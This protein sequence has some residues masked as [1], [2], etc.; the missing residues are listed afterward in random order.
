ME[1]NINYRK[2]S[3]LALV[4]FVLS[5][6]M[7]LMVG[8]TSAEN[9]ANVPDIPDVVDG[10]TQIPEVNDR[11][12]RD[13]GADL[14]IEEIENVEIEMPAIPGPSD[15]ADM[16]DEEITYVAE[17]I[18]TPEKYV[19]DRSSAPIEPVTMS[20]PP[21]EVKGTEKA[22]VIG[23]ETWDLAGSPYNITADVTITGTVTIDPGVVVQFNGSFYIYVDGYLDAVG[24]VA[25]QITFTSNMAV[26]APG[27]WG[28]I[29]IN[30]TGNAHI[31]YC[32]IFYATNAI[33]LRNVGSSVIIDYCA[34]IDCSGYGIVYSGTGDFGGMNVHDN[35]FGNSNYAIY[36]DIT[37]SSVV[38][39]T[40]GDITIVDN[41][42]GGTNGFR[43]SVYFDVV[44]GDSVT[45]GQTT[46]TGNSI[47]PTGNWGIYMD[48]W[49]IND[50]GAGTVNWGDMTITGN[51]IDVGGEDGIF[52]WGEFDTLASTT[53]N[54]GQIDVSNNGIDAPSQGIRWAWWQIETLTGTASVTAGETN[55]NDNTIDVGDEGILFIMEHIGYDMYDTA[56]VDI[57][58]ITIDP[59]VI[60]VPTNEEGIYFWDND[61]GYCGSEMYDDSTF[62]LGGIHV[63]D[64]DLTGGN[65]IT[66]NTD[67]LG[68]NN[69]GNSYASF[70]GFYVN[71]NTIDTDGANM[72]CISMPDF[73]NF[74]YDLH[75]Y[76][77]VD[78]GMFQFNSNV[79]VSDDDNGLDIT[80]F[81]NHGRYLYD[82]AQANFAGY[83]F[84][85]NDIDAGDDGIYIY[86]FE[87]HG[88]DLYGYSQVTQGDMSWSDNTI[89]AGVRGI[90]GNQWTDDHG[91]EMHDNSRYTRGDF[92]CQG[93]IIDANG[94][95]GIDINYITDQGQYLY[96]NAI[97]TFGGHYFTSNTIDATGAGMDID[98]VEEWG[99]E[100]Y[101][102]SQ[103]IFGVTQF[104]YNI[105]DCNGNGWDMDEWEYHGYVV[106]NAASATFGNFEFNGNTIS[107]NGD[108]GMHLDDLDH[109]GY[110]VNGDS[111]VTFGDFQCNGN[112]ITVN[113]INGIHAVTFG[114]HGQNLHD[115][116]QVTFGN[117][118]FNDNI[119]D[120]DE[121][122]ISLDD[123]EY[124]GNDLN[125]D[126]TATFG[127]FQVNGNEITTNGGANGRGLELLDFN[128]FGSD[129]H[130][131]SHASF[132]NF[133]FN[134][135]II[136]AD[137]YGIY[138]DDAED[139]GQ[140]LDGTCTATFGHFQMNNND[141]WA[142]DEDGFQLSDFEDHGRDLYDNSQVTFGNF[143]MNNN[144]IDA[145]NEGIEFDDI[146]YWG[147][148]VNGN[149][150]VT[151]GDIQFMTNT[152]WADNDDGF[153]FNDWY[154]L[155]HYV[156]DT[157]TVTFGDICFDHNYIDS[158]DYGFYLSDLYNWAYD[159]Y[160][161]GIVTFG[162]YSMS[163]NE[164]YTSDDEGIYIDDFEYHGEGLY[165][166]A[167]VVFGDHL[168]N[169]NYM[170][171]EG[172]GIYFED[173]ED[174]GYTMED[175]A[176][177][178]MG[179][180]LLNHNEIYSN[181]E[182]I[183][184]DPYYFGY[185]MYDNTVATY[186][187]FDLNGNYIECVDT[188]I[189]FE[190]EYF[191]YEL[192]N[193]VQVF[194]GANH[195]MN[196][197]V[198]SDDD[199]GIYA[200]WWY[201][202]GCYMYDNSYCQVGSVYVNN[203]EAYGG[204]ESAIWTGPWTTG[205]E[206]YDNA[207]V[208]LGSYY[209]NYNDVESDYIGIE[210]DYYE[211]GYYVYNWAQVTM[212]NVQIMGNTIDAD[213]DGIYFEF[214][215]NG[216][217]THAD[218]QITCGWTEIN[219]ND[220]WA[221]TGGGYA[222]IYFY[223]YEVSYDMWGA[224]QLTVGDINIYD[225]TIYDSNYGLY[226]Y[227]EENGGNWDISSGMIP[228]VYVY[229]CT[230][231]AEDWGLYIESYNS[232]EGKDT[233]ATQT[234]GPWRV[235]GCDFEVMDG[236][237]I[238]MEGA[239]TQPVF[240][241]RSC[242]FWNN[243][244]V[245]AE[246]TDDEVDGGD[247]NITPLA[248][249]VDE[250]KWWGTV[251]LEATDGANIFLDHVT[252]DNFNFG[253]YAT[254]GAY[255]E[256]DRG[257]LKDV[258]TTDV[259]LDNDAYVYM[260]G[261]NFDKTNRVFNDIA[262]SRLQVA[263]Y[264][265]VNVLDEYGYGA[266][267]AQ[268]NIKGPQSTHQFIVDTQGKHTLLMDD[269]IADS[270]GIIRDFNSYTFTATKAE[271]TGETR[272]DADQNKNVII[273]LGEGLAEEEEQQQPSIPGGKATNTLGEVW[274]I[275]VLILVPFIFA[276]YIMGPLQKRR[277]SKSK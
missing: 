103:A 72:D 142:D 225:N 116:A 55:I 206:L 80:G 229:D 178:T 19:P 108:Y 37:P 107:S 125:E 217:E 66:L 254:G 248:P 13:H 169:S 155:G 193:N 197:N 144:L 259:E 196:N 181:A 244:D 119:L 71:S 261:V 106:Y 265:T 257:R 4:F 190:P 15:T 198:D 184:F 99:R 92:C 185:D 76:A 133:E 239:A 1:S 241:V 176:T 41:L 127:N 204:G 233:G 177:F 188:G 113:N 88:R 223:M 38:T 139:W 187:D 89:V 101:D 33:A 149:S 256:M 117:T 105:I 231:E 194:H 232:P 43:L 64:N 171:V 174:F 77:Q 23:T 6:S 49:G 8:I 44:T 210:F 46:I 28:S 95:N 160:D 236:N 258:G 25:N 245:K 134:S 163:W 147:Y 27:D 124:W 62:T 167:Q 35:L 54:L 3:A 275:F 237:G 5:S 73:A 186:G 34:I 182:G 170:D 192:Y 100:L 97:A 215:E 79:G 141:I 255:V 69:W 59:N 146:M 143:Q 47:T 260:K 102:N 110:D 111:V 36:L 50:M 24:T 39:A 130:T 63:L 53:V 250:T 153:D 9:G 277:K 12:T 189:E 271:A 60:L 93:N 247:V 120:V 203:N 74:A 173:I 56:S 164:I 208:D 140:S 214:E 109:W 228:G 98:Y 135:N 121:D 199:Y 70:G 67:N 157:S 234:W 131:N 90:Y 195:I 96:D 238:F 114:Y 227:S 20:D 32:D 115:N 91:Y 86:T 230:F 159:V 10:N 216:Y 235:S 175:R 156:Y 224:S 273:R 81:Q 218:S 22:G 154:S 11:P 78:F 179:V 270:T 48:L 123:V 45:V 219:N 112:D 246:P 118:E 137:D 211:V 251:G 162:D 191:G 213:E 272:D 172:G 7:F 150:Q 26:P 222:G 84:C 264:I 57:G 61:V 17:V 168:F 126:S 138:W 220:I 94:G 148:E 200:W 152:I 267:G 85:H 263:W 221:G 42:V 87:H 269:F 266:A 2:I 242:T 165:D 51:V 14:D 243:N 145:D 262:G 122:G 21:I 268:V 253:I 75:E 205:Y 68:R 202:F 52:F 29:R 249:P 240:T 129:L 82:N 65:G 201:E 31:S 158:Y 18:D 104:S 16:D 274:W 207:R 128:D 252:L 226:L 132:G 161:Y 136:W 209:V 183:Y 180:F 58:N 30:P 166:D 83:E 276:F 40:V 151:F 212:G